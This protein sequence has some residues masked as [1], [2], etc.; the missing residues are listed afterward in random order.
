VVAD[1]PA[2]DRSLADRA[3]AGVGDWS[4]LDLAIVPTRF[5]GPFTHA[6]FRRRRQ[7]CSTQA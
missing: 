1:A 6:G 5:L 7:G 2:S 4:T 3:W